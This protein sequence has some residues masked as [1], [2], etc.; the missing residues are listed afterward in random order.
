[1]CLPSRK[2]LSDSLLDRKH[3]D[4][5]TGVLASIKGSYVCLS[6]DGFTNVNHESVVNYLATSHGKSYFLEAVNTGAQ[7]HT[8]AWLASDIERIVLQYPEANIVGVVTDNTSANKLAWKL[9][10]V[11]YPQKFFYGVCMF[12][13]LFY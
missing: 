6:T 3:A 9:L 5:K 11:K 7:G 2:Q 13:G 8:A 4:I 12:F 1:M 10:S